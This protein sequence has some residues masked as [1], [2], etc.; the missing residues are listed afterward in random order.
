M[1][2]T[3]FSDLKINEELVYGAFIES[4]TDKIDVF[5][6]ASLGCI[7]LNNDILG[8][9][10]F[11]EESFIKAFS[12]SFRSDRDPNSFSNADGAAISED[13]VNRFKFFGRLGPIEW[14]KSVLKD[15]KGV[16]E[17]YVSNAIGLEVSKYIMQDLVRRAVAGAYTVVNKITTGAK[18]TAGATEALQQ[19]TLVDLLALR[20]DDASRGRLLVMDSTSY[21]Q[22]LAKQAIKDKIPG[23]A[24][25]MVNAGVI[26]TSGVPFLVLDNDDLRTITSNNRSHDRVLLLNEGAVELSVSDLDQRMDEPVNTESFKVVWQGEYAAQM[27][28]KGAEYLKGAADADQ[29]SVNANPS[30]AS[31]RTAAN[32]SYKYASA[33]DGP[34]YLGVYPVV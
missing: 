31:L 6:Q 18:H 12:S 3:A 5:N 32:W 34:G 16:D 22:R 24:D 33:H 19:E 9:S 17:N 23:V 14:G 8:T 10:F 26:Q 1:P 7:T 30:L 2:T 20:G 28:V 29:G 21:Y 27:K 25:Q 4:I 15:L 13:V 11:Q